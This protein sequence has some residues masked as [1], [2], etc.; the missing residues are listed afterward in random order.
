MK[1]PYEAT[2]PGL[3]SIDFQS[4]VQAFRA[5]VANPALTQD[6]KRRA[7]AVIVHHAALF[8]QRDAGFANVGMALHDACRMWLDLSATTSH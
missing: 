7:Y 1:T 5:T 8:D 6:D 4:E 3:T 2:E